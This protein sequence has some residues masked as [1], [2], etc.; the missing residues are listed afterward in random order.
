MDKQKMDKK[1]F[2]YVLGL[3]ILV[4][5]LLLF[6]VFA[7]FDAEAEASALHH[8]LAFVESHPM[9]EVTALR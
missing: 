9:N 8:A 4:V 5:A 7:D 1:V 2:R 3:V 6:I